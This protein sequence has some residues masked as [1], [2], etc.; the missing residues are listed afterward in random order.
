MQK[1]NDWLF[2]GRGVTE[3]EPSEYFIKYVKKS[4]KY[5]SLEVWDLETVPLG[6]ITHDEAVEALTAWKRENLKNPEIRN[7]Q[8]V[9]VKL[10][11]S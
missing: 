10:V 11:A 7:I 5:K 1:N 6:R 8:L 9:E 4:L 2:G 3:F